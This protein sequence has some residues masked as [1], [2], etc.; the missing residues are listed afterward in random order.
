MREDGLELLIAEIGRA[1][2]RH[3]AVTLAH[4][5]PHERRR[6]PMTGELRTV[7]ALTAGMAVVA[8]RSEHLRSERG[9]RRADRTRVRLAA[10]RRCVRGC[11]GMTAASGEGEREHD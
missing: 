1:E 10:G 6:E 9:V 2:R 4:G 8:L 7:S 11:F 5:L 3:A